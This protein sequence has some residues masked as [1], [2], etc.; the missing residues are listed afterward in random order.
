MEAENVNG[1]EGLFPVVAIT[2]AFGIALFV[3]KSFFIAS[4][5]MFLL[6][7]VW[8]I[9]A[10]KQIKWSIY[11]KIAVKTLVLE[12]VGLNSILICPFLE[13]S[14]SFQI[15]FGILILI[16]T[17]IATITI[18]DARVQQSSGSFYT[19]S[20]QSNNLQKL[21]PNFRDGNYLKC[22]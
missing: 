12:I 20:K 9:Y 14:E 18:I 5:V 22:S 21:K 10:T 11:K 7:L 17:G 13:V 3:A 1:D 4:G 6:Y 8:K 15:L 19:L 16:A 2:V